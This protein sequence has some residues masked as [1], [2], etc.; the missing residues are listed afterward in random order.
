M[1]TTKLL[2]ATLS[3]AM[4]VLL[5]TL[6]DEATPNAPPAIA[7]PEIAAPKIATQ[8]KSIPKT[9][10]ANARIQKILGEECSFAFEDLAL[11]E[12]VAKLREEFELPAVLDRLSLET[13]GIETTATITSD[14]VNASLQ[15]VLHNALK[16]LGLRAVAQN[17]LLYI[18]VDA[19]AFAL[20]GGKMSYW[21]RLDEER[22]TEILEKLEVISDLDFDRVALDEAVRRVSLM[23]KLQIGIDTRA[24]EDIGLS[25][26]VPVYC[27]MRKIKLIDQLRFLLGPSDLAFTIRNNVLVI[28]TQED[29]QTEDQMI[30][31]LY[32]LDGTGLAGTIDV[33]SLIQSTVDPQAWESLGGPCTMWVGADEESGRLQMV[34]EANLDVHFAVDEL[35]ETLRKSQRLSNGSFASP[36]G[37]GLGGMGGGAGG[38]MGGMGMGGMGMGGMGM[39]GMM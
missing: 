8:K 36:P 30:A 38:G 9:S 28:T 32:L 35:L 24:L 17:D 22:V 10:S 21:V 4:L 33:T 13:A 20:L 23:H 1:F 26:D 11:D 25:K 16:P 14:L 2:A 39:G 15:G 31:R 19:Q 18:T 6:Q 29:A 5:G 12:L 7:A 27:D 34:I 37:P 3:L